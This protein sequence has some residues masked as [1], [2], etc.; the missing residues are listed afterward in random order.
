MVMEVA[1]V[2]ELGMEGKYSRILVLCN[3]LHVT[4]DKNKK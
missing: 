3:H 2:Q 1:N 4:V